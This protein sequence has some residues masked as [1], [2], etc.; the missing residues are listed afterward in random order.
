MDTRRLRLLPLARYKLRYLAHLLFDREDWRNARS[1]VWATLFSRDAG[2][3]L[4]DALYRHFPLAGPYPRQL[5][6]EVTT[7]CNL[8]CTICEHT[9]WTEKARHMT[10]EEFKRIMDQFPGLRW[11]GMTGIGSGFLNPDYMRMLRFLKQERHCFVEFFDHFLMMDADRATELIRMGIN[12]IWVSLESASRESYNRIRVGSDFDTVVAN[13]RTMMRCKRELK[14]P[15]PEL[16][17]H[18]IVNRHNVDEMEDYVELVA[19]LAKEERWLSAPIIYWTNLLP[20]EDVRDLVSRPDSARMRDIE[21]MCRDR[22]IFAVVNENVACDKPMSS[23]TKWNEPFVLVSGHLQPCCALNEA[24]DRRYQEE[25]AF[26]NVLETDFRRWWNS[27]KKR[28]FLANLRSG[29]VNPV[30]KN[31]HIF[32]HPAAATNISIRDYEQEKA[33]GEREASSENAR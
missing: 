33:R 27:S 30:C 10:F 12:K 15:I 32:R 9:Y 20:F 8:R 1:Y 4:Q 17:F 3:A 11:C 31:C 29:R 26:I 13:L 14:S 23:C 21:R 25:H 28:E 19:D 6:I 5:E 7:A 2:L 22:G 18:F 16:W 24:N